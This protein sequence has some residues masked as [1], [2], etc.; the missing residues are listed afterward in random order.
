MRTVLALLALP[1]LSACMAAPSAGRPELE[2]RVS[3]M[4]LVATPEPA[5]AAEPALAGGFGAALN[6]VRADAGLGQLRPHPRL[7]AAAAAHA[8][9]MARAG[10]VSHRGRD[11][12][13]AHARA[14]ASGCAAGYLAENI[15]WGQRSEQAVF[16]GWMASP[17]HH[18]N[19]M[20]RP[21]GVYGL[22][23]ANG[24]WVLMFADRC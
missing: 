24:L 2:G 19:M 8:R 22:G 1:L 9:D 3:T 16:A 6:D 17:G 10:Y 23:Q 12:S 15:A 21:Y 20:G 14:Q 7:A 4:S 18:R 13:S 5:P 11:G